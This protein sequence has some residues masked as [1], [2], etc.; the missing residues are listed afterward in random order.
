MYLLGG[1]GPED[2]LRKNDR[3]VEEDVSLG[4]VLG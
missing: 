2:F 3:R 4:L 1:S